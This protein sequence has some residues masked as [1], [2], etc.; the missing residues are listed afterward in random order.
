MIFIKS[1]IVLL[2][3]VAIYV[4]STS[5]CSLFRKRKQIPR[6]DANEA[7]FIALMCVVGVLT[8]AWISLYAFAIE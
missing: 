3:M 5:L 8:A 2:G 4:F 7:K 6:C 1:I